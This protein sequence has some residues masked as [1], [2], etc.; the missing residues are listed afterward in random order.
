[1]CLFEEIHDSSSLQFMSPLLLE[2]SIVNMGRYKV[3]YYIAN[4]EFF[5]SLWYLFV[6]LHR[7]E[8]GSKRE[9]T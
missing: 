6:L 9:M 1:M 2:P 3:G 4:V 5:C 7:D 8:Y